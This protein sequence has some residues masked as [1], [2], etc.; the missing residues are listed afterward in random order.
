MRIVPAQFLQRKQF[1]QLWQS[2]KNSQCSKAVTKDVERYKTATRSHPGRRSAKA[3]EARDPERVGK[4]CSRPIS[5]AGTERAAAGPR[6]N[7]IRALGRFGFRSNATRRGTRHAFN[8]RAKLNWDR[9]LKRD[10]RPGQTAAGQHTHAL[11]AEAVT[12]STTYLFCYPPLVVCFLQQLRT[13]C[14]ENSLSSPDSAQWRCYSTA[15]R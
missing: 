10:L 5:A 9:K 13:D 3:G 15:R 8:E 4:R 6:F 12:H 14:R 11:C 7:P 2:R 1:D